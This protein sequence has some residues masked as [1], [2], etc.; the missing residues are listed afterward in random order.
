MEVSGQQRTMA[1]DQGERPQP[2]M[3]PGFEAGKDEA[4]EILT[5]EVQKAIN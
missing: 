4:V 2:Y 5:N 1:H 3:E